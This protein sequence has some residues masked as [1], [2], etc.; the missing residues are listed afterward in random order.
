[1]SVPMTNR[2]FWSW[3][4]QRIS[5][6]FLIFF[7]GLHVLAIHFSKDWKVTAATVAARLGE[8]PL[9]ALFYYLFIPLAVYHGLNGVWGI[10]LDYAPSQPVRRGW[11]ACLWVVGVGLTGFGYWVFGGLLGLGRGGA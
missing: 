1:M 7:L 2:G 4:L 3:V 6:L 10:I 8:N 11:G 5:G 9:W